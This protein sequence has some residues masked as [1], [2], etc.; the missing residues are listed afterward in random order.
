M[1]ATRSKLLSERYNN[2]LWYVQTPEVPTSVAGP[3]PLTQVPIRNDHAFNAKAMNAGAMAA[4]RALELEE[5][6]TRVYLTSMQQS[7][8]QVRQA[9]AT[10]RVH[11]C[12]GL[13][14]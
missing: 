11:D 5:E 1:S 8:D 14:A 10:S 13:E 3:M 6:A 4:R 2:H 7:P 9:E 12:V